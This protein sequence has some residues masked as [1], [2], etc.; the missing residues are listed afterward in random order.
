MMWIVQ[1]VLILVMEPL[2]FFVGKVQLQLQQL[3]Q[4]QLQQLLQLQLLHH[5]HLRVEVVLKMKVSHAVVL[6]DVMV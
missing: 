2:R 3:L 6:V 4:L 1:L 5:P